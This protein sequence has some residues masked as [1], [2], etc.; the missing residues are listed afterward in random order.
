MTHRVYDKFDLVLHG[1]FE[2]LVIE[3]RILTV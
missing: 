1:M 2:M 3:E